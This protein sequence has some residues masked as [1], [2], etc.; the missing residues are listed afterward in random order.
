[1]ASTPAGS[2]AWCLILP[3]RIGFKHAAA[4][5]SGMRTRFA[6]PERKG[7]GKASL[8]RRLARVESFTDAPIAVIRGIHE[9]EPTDLSPTSLGIARL[10]IR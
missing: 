4:R 7:P 8:G 6:R 9:E 5:L 10:K 2:V 3:E 1:M